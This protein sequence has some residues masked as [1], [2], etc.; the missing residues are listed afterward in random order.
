MSGEPMIEK[1][2]EVGQLVEQWLDD[3][4]VGR[5]I[6]EARVA[7]ACGH[8]HQ[9]VVLDGATSVFHRCRANGCACNEY[10][11]ASPPPAVTGEAM[12]LV[13]AATEILNAY[14]RGY[15][16]AHSNHAQRAFAALRA[17][18]PSEREEA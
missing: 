12:S 6:R 5:A 17:A 2:P 15:V 18:L 14:D 8:D 16:R 3:A 1:D 13:Q 7:C 4:D 10:R 9:T 11:P